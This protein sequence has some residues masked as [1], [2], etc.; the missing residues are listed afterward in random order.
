MREFILSALKHVN[1]M[2]DEQLVSLLRSLEEEYSLFE[3]MMDSLY[4]GLILLDKNNNLVKNNRASE[5]ILEMRLTDLQEK[6]IWDHI[7]YQNISQFIHNAVQREEAKKTALFPINKAMGTTYVEV[8]VLP[9]VLEKKVIGTIIVLKDVTKQKQDEIQRHRLESLASLTNAAASVAHE[10]KNPLGA[11]S[12]H[13]QLLKKKIDKLEAPD[14]TKE[15]LLKHITVIDEEIENLNKTVVDFLFA[16]RPIKFDFTQVNINSLLQNLLSLYEDEFKKNNIT[17]EFDLNNKIAEIMG[18]ERFLR[19]AFSNIITNAK[20]AMPNGGHFF[21]STYQKEN[22]VYIKFEDTGCGISEENMH[23]IFEPYFTTKAEGT[24]LGLTLTYKVIKE[25]GGDIFLQSQIGIG[26]TFIFSLPILRK[27][28][29]LLLE[30]RA[31][32]DY[33][34]TIQN[35]NSLQGGA[36]SSSGNARF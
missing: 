31:M 30:S 24:G 4:D 18:D 10:I 8:S 20:A 28:E 16:V 33:D 21:I 1:Q 23:K 14:T 2:S 27:N 5:R 9:L 12:I 36:A 15:R 3:A 19:Q 32:E 22:S 26:T 13:A 29:R 17:V 25:H 6:K 11:M 7:E 34:V 35:D